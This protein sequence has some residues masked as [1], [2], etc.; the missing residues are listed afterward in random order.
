MSF[1]NV[2]AVYMPYCLQRQEDGRYAILNREYKPLGFLTREWITYS[3]YPVC[4]KIKG[5][6]PATA[7]KLSYKGSEDTD[8]IFLYND[9]CNPC[10]GPEEM[11]AYL[12][13]L[14]LLGKLRIGEEISPVLGVR[15]GAA[16]VKGE[17]R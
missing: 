12:K 6:G 3:D 7:R 1:N 8:W 17:S 15:I 10:H 9:G 11:E 16:M 13:K 4:A 14:S 2:T 5:I